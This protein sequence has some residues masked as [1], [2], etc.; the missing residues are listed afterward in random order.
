MEEFL[1][2]LYSYENFSTYLI[3]AIIVLIILFFVILFFGNKDK[4]ERE[5]EATKKLMKINEENLNNE[6][7]ESTPKEEKEVLESDTIIVPT[8]N[9]VS[10]PEPI[11]EPVPE[12]V[13][14]PVEEE[15]PVIP[16]VEPLPE[17]PTDSILPDVIDKEYELVDNTPV[18][19]EADGFKEET[20]EE[21]VE[22]PINDFEPVLFNEEEKP[23]VVEEEVQHNDVKTPEFDYDEVIRN[24]ESFVGD[25]HH[26]V[27][28]GPEVFS[29][30]YIPEEKK[31]IPKQEIVEEDEIEL[32]ILKKDVKEKSIEEKIEIPEI[33]NFNFEDISGETYNIK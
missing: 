15:I 32:P 28:K 11:P 18:V 23:L 24:V 5:I 27:Q 30:V 29:S 1:T 12:P 14:P 10:N 9:E 21:K 19:P 33:T 22:V 25:E 2:K 8:I 26:E 13:L 6:L 16:E 17:V 20:K 7:A 4:K 3:I 31:E